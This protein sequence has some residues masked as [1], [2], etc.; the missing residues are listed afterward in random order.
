MIISDLTVTAMNNDPDTAL[1]STPTWLDRF[2]AR[3][4]DHHAREGD[5]WIDGTGA[6][7]EGPRS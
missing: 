2:R 6:D 7:V 5:W 1:A 4:L 3:S